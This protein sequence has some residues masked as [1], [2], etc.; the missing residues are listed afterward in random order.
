MKNESTAVNNNI[1]SIMRSGSAIPDSMNTNTS[2][3]VNFVNSRKVPTGVTEDNLTREEIAS[4]FKYGM[5]SF[6]EKIAAIQKKNEEFSQSFDLINRSIAQ[7]SHFLDSANQKIDAIQLEYQKSNSAIVDGIDRTNHEVGLTNRCVLN[8]AD[9]LVN[10]FDVCGRNSI[11][12]TA[13]LKSIENALIK[14]SAVNVQK[15]ESP[16]TSKRTRSANRLSDYYNETPANILA[17]IEKYRD[18]HGFKSN[19]GAA[20]SIAYKMSKKGHIDMKELRRSKAAE[21]HYSNV[22]FGYLVNNDSNLKELFDLVV[23]EH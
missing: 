15:T 22:C 3:I 1:S 5:D 12:Q 7:I 23:E 17:K 18:K 10:I 20:H 4:Y 14:S 16:I 19:K 6:D 11:N 8:A 13:L 9:T 2:N 21:V